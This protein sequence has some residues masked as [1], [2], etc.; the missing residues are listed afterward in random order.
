MQRSL[1]LDLAQEEANEAE[2]GDADGRV[3]RSQGESPQIRSARYTALLMIICDCG[4]F[5]CLAGCALCD[6]CI[7]LG[8]CLFIIMLLAFGIIWMSFLEGCRLKTG[9]NTPR[10]ALQ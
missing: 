10:D 6:H 5:V 8:N 9:F 3:D 4:L 7:L 1:R 2:V